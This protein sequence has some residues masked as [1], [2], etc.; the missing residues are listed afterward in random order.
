MKNCEKLCRRAYFL[1][2]AAVCVLVSATAWADEPD[3]DKQALE[4]A[5]AD[6][7]EAMEAAEAHYQMAVQLYGQ[8][9]YRE[10]VE[11]FDKVL[12]LHDDPIVHC[13]RAVPLIEIGRLAEA[14]TSLVA[15][16]EGYPEES[17]DYREVT[18]EIEALTVTLDVVE[19][20]AR[21]VA[22]SV[23]GADDDGDEAQPVVLE[24]PPVDEADGGGASTVQMMG[25]VLLGTGIGL[26]G[27][28]AVV[29]WR[30]ADMVEEYR[31]QSLGGEGTSA[32]RHAEL[33][34]QIETRQRIFW[35]LA[36]TG[37]AAATVGLGLSAWGLFRGSKDEGVSVDV[38]MDRLMAN[39]AVRF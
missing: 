22:E 37:G 14:R 24:P 30:S 6:E 23:A 16:R 19:P 5:G 29:D 20:R 18:A 1:I 25:L 10:S 31:Q 35:G 28:A 9:R 38:G 7:L 3:G 32:Q 4:E 36:I 13:N 27:A 33:R 8:G 34:G 2:V 15:C 21:D 26:G 39:W 12:E 11:E 17:A